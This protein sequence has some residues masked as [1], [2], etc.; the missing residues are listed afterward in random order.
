SICKEIIRD[1]SVIL[2]DA[3]YGTNKHKDLLYTLL[4]PDPK[5][6]KEKTQSLGR[7]LTSD[8]KRSLESELFEDLKYL[9]NI[10]NI[11]VV[12]E[13]LVTFFEK[14]KNLVTFIAYFKRQWL[15][16]PD[17]YRNLNGINKIMWIKAYR[18]RIPRTNMDTTNML[19][20]WH[21]R[22]KY[23]NFEGKVNRRIDVLI[24]ELYV[25]MDDDTWQQWHLGDVRAG[26]MMPAEKEVRR[27]QIK[28]QELHVYAIILRYFSS[29]SKNV[30]LPCQKW[31]QI[32]QPQQQVPT[33]EEL[34][35]NIHEMTQ[36]LNDLD[37]NSLQVVRNQLSRV[38]ED[39][40]RP[41]RTFQE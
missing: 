37:V 31:Q 18:T 41:D 23:N 33:P 9:M 11:N 40:R 39:V 12:D 3:T 35:H 8:E 5:T 32:Q 14:W 38:L 6:G 15:N 17:E 19:E 10:D 7:K 26:R 29:P 27:K 34:I 36:N 21:K 20:S 22:L 25:V 16:E 4:S 13:V 1:I 28:A 2:L 30:E 24:Y